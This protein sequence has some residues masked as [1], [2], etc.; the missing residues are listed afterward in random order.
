MT[1][2]EWLDSPG[3]SNHPGLAPFEK[4]CGTC[5]AI[6]GFTDGGERDAPKLFAWGSPQWIARMIRK[7]GATE[8]YGYLKV[9]EQMPAF[10]SDQLIQNDVDMVIRYLKEEYLKPAAA[11]SGH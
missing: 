8:N 4:E 3:V 1:P 2:D 10:A 7:P 11:L 6:D 9:E 5:H